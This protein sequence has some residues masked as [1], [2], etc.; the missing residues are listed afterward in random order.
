M[1]Y[2]IHGSSQVGTSSSLHLHICQLVDKFT[3]SSHH[4]VRLVGLS[5]S[6]GLEHEVVTIHAAEFSHRS[7]SGHSK[8]EGQYKALHI[9]GISVKYAVIAYCC[10]SEVLGHTPV[11]AISE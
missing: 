1:A 5:R 2:T 8:A 11:I 7:T 3:I 6:H 9:V 4:Q 10:G